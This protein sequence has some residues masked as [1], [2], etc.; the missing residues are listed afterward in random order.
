L[1]SQFCISL[2]VFFQLSKNASVVSIYEQVHL[3]GGGDWPG[4]AGQLM[5]SAPQT[6]ATKQRDWQ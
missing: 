6:V 2:T 3:V 4:A 1:S 5:G